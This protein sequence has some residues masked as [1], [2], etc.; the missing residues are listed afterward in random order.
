MEELRAT[1]SRLNK[2]S[3]IEFPALK[4]EPEKSSD[5]EE[6]ENSAELKND[7]PKKDGPKKDEPKNVNEFPIVKA[8]KADKKVE[9][10]PE[11]KDGP[12]AQVEEEFADLFYS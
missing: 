11:A 9:N 4:K 5:S 6:L 7:E 12:D 8:G 10:G 3:L 1:M 2:R